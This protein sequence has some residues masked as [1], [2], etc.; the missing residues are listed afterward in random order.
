MGF[1]QCTY[2]LRSYVARLLG[3]KQD[4]AASMGLQM[5]AGCVDRQM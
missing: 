4:L 3:C 5:H 2:L 1:L